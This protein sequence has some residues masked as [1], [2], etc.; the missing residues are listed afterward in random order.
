MESV[1]RLRCPRVPPRSRRICCPRLGTPWSDGAEASLLSNRLGQPFPID[2]AHG[3]EGCRL[4]AEASTRFAYPRRF[5]EIGRATSEL[6]SL[7]RT[8]YAVFCLK[9]NT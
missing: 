7:V 6:Q 5:A 4:S 8:S 2:P 9:K 3:A 1:E